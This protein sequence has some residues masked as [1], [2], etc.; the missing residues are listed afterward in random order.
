MFHF[1]DYGR[2]GICSNEIEY[3]TLQESKLF[4]ISRHHPL[5]FVA[6]A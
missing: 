4:N 1:H 6:G 5:I 2:K 3:Q